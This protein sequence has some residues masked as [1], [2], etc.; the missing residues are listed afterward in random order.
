MA[1]LSKHIVDRAAPGAADYF[2][3]DD[4]LAGFGLRVFCSGKRRG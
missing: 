2:I 1:K 3:W 4:Q